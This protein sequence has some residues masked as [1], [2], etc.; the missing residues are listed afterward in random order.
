MPS[1]YAL[2][3]THGQATVTIHAADLYLLVSTCNLRNA[4]GGRR[5]NAIGG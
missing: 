1:D 3:R 5:T 4:E 2:K